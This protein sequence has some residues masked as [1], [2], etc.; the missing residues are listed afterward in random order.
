[1]DAT[2]DVQLL[3]GQ[4]RAADQAD[5]DGALENA[6]NS[7]LC[8]SVCTH[9]ASPVTQCVNGHTTCNVCADEIVARAHARNIG[10]RN[11]RVGVYTLAP[12]PTCRIPIGTYN[13]RRHKS[14]VKMVVNRSALEV[15]EAARVRV[16]CRYACNGCEAPPMPVSELST[17]QAA[18]DHVS[19]HCVNGCGWT[20]AVG[21]LRR[22][23]APA[24]LADGERRGGWKNVDVPLC[25][26]TA[27]TTVVE[28]ER[29]EWT[30]L[31]VHT[32]VGTSE[33]GCSLDGKERNVVVDEVVRDSVGQCVTT[34]P[35]FVLT[36]LPVT[37]TRE[38]PAQTAVAYAVRVTS[39]VPQNRPARDV[40]SIMFGTGGSE[41]TT[42]EQEE[43]TAAFVTQGAWPGDRRSAAG[44]VASASVA[45]VTAESVLSQRGMA[46]SDLD[47]C[48]R[49][50]RTLNLR[51]CVGPK[52]R[53]GGVGPLVDC[54]PPPA[55]EEMPQPPAT[56]VFTAEK[57][58]PGA[59]HWH[60]D[61]RAAAP[62]ELVCRR[63][64]NHGIP[65][66]EMRGAPWD[67]Q[68]WLARM[69]VLAVNA[70]DR[71]VEPLSAVFFGDVSN[72]VNPRGQGLAAG[73]DDIVRLTNAADAADGSAAAV[74]RTAEARAPLALAWFREALR[75]THTLAPGEPPAHRGTIVTG[76]PVNSQ[77]RECATAR[78]VLRI[79]DAAAAAAA[80][81]PRPAKRRRAAA[82]APRP[83]AVA[84]AQP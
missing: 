75:A 70:T 15:A 12:C 2:D 65:P 48:T 60:D 63:A 6:L 33:G 46:V 11:D 4:L 16:P 34:K 49:T 28:I 18:C 84:L 3:T 8:C 47:W 23:L 38:E 79:S 29:H 36:I 14:A 42:D 52:G 35:A 76:V 17:H 83:A 67:A 45:I 51:L 44:L 74:G 69:A 37:V 25:T 30:A 64:N 66:C 81:A 41:A 54:G 20:G 55:W 13:A 40:C 19:V 78:A 24:F 50:V 82:P 58:Q 59:A 31:A 7:I 57:R 62:S 68:G 39:L 5:T 73:L 43:A 32:V 22:H 53:E 27:A 56:Y 61:V 80:A 72:Q 10:L 77:R 21:D 71:L 9:V 1:M 26:A